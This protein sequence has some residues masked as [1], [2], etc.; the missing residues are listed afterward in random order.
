M[1]L[2]ILAGCMIYLFL[3][4]YS[5]KKKWKRLLQ[6]LEKEDKREVPEIKELRDSITELE[7]TVDRACKS[8]KGE[9]EKTN[10]K[11]C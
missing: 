6:K 11:N 1:I 5:V 7:E 9:I 10:E 4:G 2:W 3:Y 8:S